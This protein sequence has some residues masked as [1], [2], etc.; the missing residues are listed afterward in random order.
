MQC[1]PQGRGKM[2]GSFLCW[3]EEQR[4]VGGRV[5]GSKWRPEKGIGI[6]GR[7]RREKEIK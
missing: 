7:K 4:I 5:G 3:V 6:K 2:Q 1:P